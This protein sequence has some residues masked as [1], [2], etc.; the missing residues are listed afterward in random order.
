MASASW[1]P[2]ILWKTVSH[3]FLCKKPAHRLMIL[4]PG[5]MPTLPVPR[6]GNRRLWTMWLQHGPESAQAHRAAV[7]RIYSSVNWHF[8]LARTHLNIRAWLRWSYCP[9]PPFL[10]QGLQN[11]TCQG[12]GVLR[13]MGPKPGAWENGWFSFCF[14]SGGGVWPGGIQSRSPLYQMFSLL[15]GPPHSFHE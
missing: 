5:S 9:T 6:S 8:A 3:V 2:V 15:P 10:F 12:L 13:P 7:R 14:T 1:A 11:L 4:L